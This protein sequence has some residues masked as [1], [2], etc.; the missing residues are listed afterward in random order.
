[1]RRPALWLAILLVLVTDAVVLMSVWRNRSGASTAI[2][3]TERELPL[4]VSDEDNTGISLRLNWIGLGPGDND[5]FNRAKLA[6][7]GFD[8][9]IPLT[10]AK[11]DINYR[12][13]LPRQ[14]FI[15]L[16]YEGDQWQAWLARQRDRAGV[17][18]DPDRP[19]STRLVAVDVAADPARLRERYPDPKKYLIVRGVVRLQWVQRWNSQARRFTGPNDLQGNVTEILPGEIHV[20]LPLAQELAKRP[21]HYT[22]GLA[23]GSHFEPWVTSVRSSGE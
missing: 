10:A 18:T 4:N 14:A 5:W 2:E 20:P 12:H 13:V 11:A 8:T 16:E 15:A 6:E 3:L 23:Y 19:T 17:G 22:V 9:S 1:M 21:K 7:V